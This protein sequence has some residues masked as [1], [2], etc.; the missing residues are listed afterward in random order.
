M[1]SFTDAS[2]WGPAGAGLSRQSSQ[3]GPISQGSING[4]TG[5]SRCRP[6]RGGHEPQRSVDIGGLGA[7]AIVP[8]VAFRSSSPAAVIGPDIFV[9]SREYCRTVL[10]V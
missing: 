4:Q 7:V 5:L 2:L 6:L 1:E 9:V 8:V 10:S 3:P